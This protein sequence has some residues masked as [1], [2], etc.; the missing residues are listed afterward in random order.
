MSKSIDVRFWE[1]VDKSGECWI[2][3]GGVAGSGYG[4]FRG[5]D[6]RMTSAHRIAYWLERGEIPEGNV[7]CHTCDVKLC[8][9]PDHLWCGTQKQNMDDMIAKGRAAKGE[10]LNHHSQKGSLNY[11]AKLD[12]FVVVEIKRLL[13]EGISQAEVARK[14]GVTRANVWNIKHKK[15]WVDT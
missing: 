13:E 7:V 1:K 6:G 11:A 5:A 2:W 4:V 10:Q 15:S 12:E 14:T 9:R 3:M 8:V